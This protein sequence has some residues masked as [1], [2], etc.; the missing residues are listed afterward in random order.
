LNTQGF[1]LQVENLSL[2]STNNG[3]YNC[4]CGFGSLTVLGQASAC[5]FL[6]NNNT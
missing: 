6:M 3:D 2:T 1:T 5:A 4:G